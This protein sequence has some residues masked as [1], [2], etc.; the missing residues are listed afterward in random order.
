MSQESRIEAF[1][2]KVLGD[3][4]REGWSCMAVFPTEEE[5][6]ENFNYTVGLSTSYR[7]PELILV[8]MN[9]DQGHGVLASAVAAIKRE[10]VFAP[11]TYSTAVLKGYR[12]AFLEVDDPFG[13]EMPMSMTHRLVGHVAC[14]QLVWPDVRDRFPWHDDFD[15]EYAGRQI[16]LGEWRGKE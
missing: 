11:D 9:L 12:V 4:E 10:A 5:P 6:G 2:L 15:S 16:L 14:L 3:I 8:G 7:H 13:G 1:E